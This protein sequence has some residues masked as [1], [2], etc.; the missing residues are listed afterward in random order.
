MPPAGGTGRFGHDKL[1]HHI[2]LGS[3]TLTE[4]GREPV[5]IDA[6]ARMAAP[7]KLP[8]D[9]YTRQPA[10][11]SLT[12]EDERHMESLQPDWPTP[13]GAS[14]KKTSMSWRAMATAQGNWERLQGSWR[15]LLAR[16]GMLINHKG[17][18]LLHLCLGSTA[19]GVLTW[20]V[21]CRPESREIFFPSSSKVEVQVIHNLDEWNATECEIR[22][23]QTSD[24]TRM[25][26][27]CVCRKGLDLV[28]WA[29]RDGF[30]GLTLFW[31]KRLCVD[32]AVSNADV[33]KPLTV[34]NYVLALAKKVLGEHATDDVLK[35]ALLRRNGLTGKQPLVSEILGQNAADL[36]AVLEQ[37]GGDDDSD[38]DVQDLRYEAQ[39]VAS[40]EQ[41]MMEKRRIIESQF[42]VV[43]PPA[44]GNQ[45]KKERQFVAVRSEGMTA[46]M[47]KQFLPP[48][49]RLYKDT[50][51][52]NRWRMFHPAIGAE[53][54][55]S[56][57]RRSAVSDW[58]AMKHLIL[59]AWQ[60]EFRLSGAECPFTFQDGPQRVEPAAGAS[61]SSM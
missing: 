17:S 31:L 19:A 2:S 35:E 51:R 21:G 54:S 42:G 25:V 20:R 37:D 55:K 8:A 26:G 27:P 24:G 23:Y 50:L 40:Q 52:E 29:A 28:K 38:H 47:A 3:N 43:G 53:R 56:F 9:S 48:H 14:W 18:G 58:G 57:G 46:E 39:M 32:V 45:T 36:A 1:Y 49:C 13:S 16:P 30:A 5:T 33:T 11:C 22:E 4:F 60:A 34:D 12:A 61:A 41:R 10:E 7:D 6:A 15:S 59:L 44:D